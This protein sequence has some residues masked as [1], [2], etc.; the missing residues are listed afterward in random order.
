LL[1]TWG[2]K[3]VSH[4]IVQ[5]ISGVSKKSFM[6][7]LLPQEQ[8]CE[9]GMTKQLVEANKTKQKQKTP[10]SLLMVGSQQK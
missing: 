4:D 5:T 3:S 1:K 7:T 10:W 9:E 8:G 6:A 2:P